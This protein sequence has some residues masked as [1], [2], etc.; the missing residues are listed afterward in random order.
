MNYSFILWITFHGI[1][2]ILWFHNLLRFISPFINSGPTHQNKN[3]NTLT[4]ARAHKYTQL[5]WAQFLFQIFIRWPHIYL[6]FCTKSTMAKHRDLTMRR[7]KDKTGVRLYNKFINFVYLPL[8]TSL[9]ADDV[10]ENE[11]KRRKR[12]PMIWKW[13]IRICSSGLFF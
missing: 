10:R 9:M 8:V 7:N 13:P 5:T 6:F 4:L 2:G 11:T 12:K 3:N 1:S